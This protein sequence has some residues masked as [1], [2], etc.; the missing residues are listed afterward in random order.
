[1]SS[2]TVTDTPSRAGA[3][4]ATRRAEATRTL[5]LE[6]STLIRRLKR[7]VGERAHDIHP[8]LQPAAYWILTILWHRGSLRAAAVADELELDKGAVSRH[9]Q[10]L[11]DLD[12]L[13]RTPDP[14]DGRATLLSLSAE[15]ERRLNSVDEQRRRWFDEVLGSW[16]DEELA[17]FAAEMSR[18]NRT[19]EAARAA[20]DTAS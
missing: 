17:G 16:S 15:G 19:L 10:H 7:V 9:V 6:L 13:D 14:D 11:L 8:E 12:L 2:P 5:E 4:S 18:Y 20:R 1:M 3:G